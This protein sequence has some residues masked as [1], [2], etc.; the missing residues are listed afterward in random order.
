MQNSILD[1]AREKIHEM[2]IRF[3]E[4]IQMQATEIKRCK[5]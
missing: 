2:E 3:E 5:I 4:I 1:I